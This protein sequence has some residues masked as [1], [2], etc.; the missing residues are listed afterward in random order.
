M[1]TA[2]DFSR[3]F[4]KA[5]AFRDPAFTLLV[6]RN[7]RGAARLGLVIAKKNLRRSVQRNRV[8]R[9]AR[10]SF[11]RA[12]LGLPPVDIVLIARRGIGELDNSRLT[13]ALEK[14]WRNISRHLSS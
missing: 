3:V 14:Q 8:K 2:S 4:D 12:R 9:L 5:R 1:L 7:R 11:R 10:E 13:R 6:R